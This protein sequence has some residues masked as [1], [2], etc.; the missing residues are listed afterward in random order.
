MVVVCMTL[1]YNISFFSQYVGA[2]KTILSL[3]HILTP[4]LAS[5]LRQ[6]PLE[7]VH[8]FGAVSPSQANTK[9]NGNEDPALLAGIKSD[10]ASMELAN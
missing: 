10:R 4:F 5:A 3:F 7:Y 9:Y 8:L 6:Q 1:K 2:H